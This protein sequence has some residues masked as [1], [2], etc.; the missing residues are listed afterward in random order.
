MLVLRITGLFTLRRLVAAAAFSRL[1]RSACGLAP[2]FIL[3]RLASLL[4]PYWNGRPLLRK[5]LICPP[6][7]RKH[8]VRLTQELPQ[9]RPGSWDGGI[10]KQKCRG[11]FVE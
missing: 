10:T 6:Q 8:L 1:G 2:T 5:A 3:L 4:H 11:I 7:R 9:I